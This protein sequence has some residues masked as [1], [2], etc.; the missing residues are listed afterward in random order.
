MSTSTARLQW[1]GTD[2]CVDFTC[3]CGFEGHID[4]YFLYYLKC[5]E[6]QKVWRMDPSISLTEERSP[7]IDPIEVPWEDGE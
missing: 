4:G 5:P 6:C 3:Q 7:H 1:K 2:A